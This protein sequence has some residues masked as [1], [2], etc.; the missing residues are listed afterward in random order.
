M[1]YL[2]W[3]GMRWGCEQ[4]E[5]VNEVLGKAVG[6]KASGRRSGK[7]LTHNPKS[8]SRNNRLLQPLIQRLLLNV[9]ERL[10]Q[11]SQNVVDSD[12]SL[13]LLRELSR[14]P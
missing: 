5:G 13:L 4:G 14:H 6:V 10:V 12:D 11:R 1:R 3:R 9:P 2:S 7:N 8:N